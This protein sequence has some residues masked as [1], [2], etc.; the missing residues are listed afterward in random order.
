[1][2]V[3]G[4]GR[5]IR[6]M[7]LSLSKHPLPLLSFKWEG[8]YVALSRVKRRD[9]IRLLVKRNDWNTVSYVKR[10]KKNEYTD[11]FFRGYEQ[12][13]RGAMMWSPQRVHQEV[14]RIAQARVASKKK[15][16]G[17]QRR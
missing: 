5:T 6:R 1:M 3:S 7:V 15:R 4:K 16:R 10:L 13:D 14:K 17:R 11:C 2:I 9:H 12:S 8:L